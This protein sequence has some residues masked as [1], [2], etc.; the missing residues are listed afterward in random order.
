VKSRRKMWGDIGGRAAEE[1]FKNWNITPMTSE[2]STCQSNSVGTIR[3]PLGLVVKRITSMTSE[4]ANDKIA[5]SIRAE[6]ILFAGQPFCRRH[7][8]H[9]ASTNKHQTH[10]SK[11]WWLQQSS[12]CKLELPDLRRD[13]IVRVQLLSRLMSAS[14]CRVFFLVL[15]IAWPLVSFVAQRHRSVGSEAKA[16]FGLTLE[17]AGLLM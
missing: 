13:I 3:G 15:F 17:R 2:I 16:S 14:N 4:S 11:F 6:G 8:V 7:R 12:F 9:D 5:R 1:I 10:K